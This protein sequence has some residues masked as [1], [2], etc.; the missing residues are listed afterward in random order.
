[1]RSLAFQAHLSQVFSKDSEAVLDKSDC[2]EIG[3][4][5]SFSLISLGFLCIGQFSLAISLA[6]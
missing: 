5:L 4:M 1:M 3:S 6:S 2:P